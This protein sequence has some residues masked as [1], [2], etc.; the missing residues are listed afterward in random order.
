MGKL[1]TRVCCLFLCL[2]LLPGCWDRRELEE[3][4]SVVAIAIDFAEGREDL[5]KLTVQIPIPLKIAG[6]SGQGGGSNADAVRVLSVTGKTIADAANNI[7]ERL[8]QRLFLGHTRVLAISEQVARRGTGEIIDAFRRDPQIRRLLW[9]IVV[10]GEAAS[11]LDIKPKLVQIPVVYIM[12]LIENGTKMGIIPNQTLGDYFI[13]TTNEAMQPMLNY[14]EVAGDEPAWR[15]VAVFH[16]YKM[17]GTL[18]DVY[19]WSLLQLRDNMKGGDVTIKLPDTDNGYVTFRPHFVGTKLTLRGSHMLKKRGRH[20]HGAIYTC[21][22]QGDI[23]EMTAKPDLPAEK[24]IPMLQGVIQKEMEKRAQKL[25]DILQGEYNSD[26]FKLGLAL[27]G[28]HFHD[29][30]SKHEWPKDFKDFP[31]EVKYV[32]K[33]RRLGMEMH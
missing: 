3:R 14:F 18:K 16:G 2:L 6:S 30:W 10:K 11:L 15:G 5:Y 29:Y 24:Q 26:V 28:R 1:W 23:I 13:Q 17:V 31:I 25:I 19:T 33:L 4:I 32:I 7:Q 27:R 22:V 8:N 9:P 21:E 12:D 20:E